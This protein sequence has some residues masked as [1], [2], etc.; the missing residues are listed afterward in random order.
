MYFGPLSCWKISLPDIWLKHVFLNNV[1]LFSSF[2]VV[3]DAKLVS[4]PLLKAT[5]EYDIATTTTLLAV[6]SW[7][8]LYYCRALF[9]LCQTDLKL[10]LIR[11]KFP[12]EH[13][14]FITW[15][16]TISSTDAMVVFQFSSCHSLADAKSMMRLLMT[17]LFCSFQT[18][19][20]ATCQCYVTSLTNTLPV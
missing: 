13:F 20:S 2:H 19:N 18:N 6:W 9:G 5:L 8:Y 7:C 11:L 10:N 1:H 12:P 4:F 15:I 17:G 3:I 14:S 16:L